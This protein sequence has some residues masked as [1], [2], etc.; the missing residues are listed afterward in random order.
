MVLGEAAGLVGL[1]AAV[2]AAG[3]IAAGRVLAAQLAG[4]RALDAITVGA[5]VVLLVAASALAIVGPLRRAMRVDAA[6][7]LRQ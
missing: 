2:G 5:A 6:E 1:G 3:A 4:V 7:A